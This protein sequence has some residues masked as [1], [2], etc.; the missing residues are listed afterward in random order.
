M[1]E[2][3]YPFDVGALYSALDDKRNRL[4]LSWQSV[5]NQL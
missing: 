3:L 5:A 1:D 2:A 4:G